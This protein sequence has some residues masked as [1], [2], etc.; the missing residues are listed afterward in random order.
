[1]STHIK[2]GLKT[3]LI[4]KVTSFEYES[5]ENMKFGGVAGITAETLHQVQ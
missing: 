1:V 2:K 4:N 5:I 3:P